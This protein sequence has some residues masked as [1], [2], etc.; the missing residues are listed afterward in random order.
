GGA[1][2]SR[3]HGWLW[4]VIGV[5]AI[6]AGCSRDSWDFAAPGLSQLETINF[7]LSATASTEMQ[8]GW[9]VYIAGNIVPGD[10]L[11]QFGTIE[12]GQVQ[13]VWT[14]SVWGNEKL[15]VGLWARD[16]AT[17]RRYRMLDIAVDSVLLTDSSPINYWEVYRDV[18]LYV[19][20]GQV[21]V[22]T[23]APDSIM[24]AQ[25]W[26]TGTAFPE[27]YLNWPADPNEMVYWLGTWTTF[28]WAPHTTDYVDGRRTDT[29]MVRKGTVVLLRLQKES[30]DELRSGVYVGPVGDFSQA[31][32]LKNLYDLGGGYYAFE[33]RVTCA[34]VFE[35][36]R[37]ADERRF[38][39]T[40]GGS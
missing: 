21:C 30:G 7:T 23:G 40:I 22:E 25:F 12:N 2:M 1:K 15:P 8:D 29:M 24:A 9:P 39:I 17:E 36:L 6:C 28:R 31:T 13:D 3:M 33:F 10:S 16:P 38:S 4:L 5:L 32:E 26:Y 14:R 37:S 11:V 35:N 20:N 19:D 27:Q 34:G 18:Q